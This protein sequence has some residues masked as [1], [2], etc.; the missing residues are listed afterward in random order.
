MICCLTDGTVSLALAISPELAIPRASIDQLGHPSGVFHAR[1][2]PLTMAQATSRIST[3]QR[4]LLTIATSP[5]HNKPKARHSMQRTTCTSV[6]KKLQHPRPEKHRHTGKRERTPVANALTCTH[7]L[8]YTGN[9][10]ARR[11]THTH[12][13]THIQDCTRVWVLSCV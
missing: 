8:F 11:H 5:A 2:P 12:T 4:A 9:A 6:P 13:C 10:H 3:Q 1:V 7:T